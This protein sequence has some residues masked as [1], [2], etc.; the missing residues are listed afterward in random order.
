MKDYILSIIGVT[1]L[2]YGLQPEPELPPLVVTYK[3]KQEVKQEVQEVTPQVGDLIRTDRTVNLSHKEFNCLAYNIF[4]EAGVEDFAGKI[5]VAQVSNNRLKTD[6]YSNMCDVVYAHKQFS[7]TLNSS[8][9]YKQPHGPLWEES[10][11]AAKA[12]VNGV[13]VF[14][15]EQVKHYH[16][17][18]ANPK[19][20]PWTNRGEQ[21]AQLG[22]HI[23]YANVQ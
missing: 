8:K 15:L 7:W 14:G 5:A 20:V 13:R 11:K 6:R 12:F 21:V 17:E 19:A 9:R 16:A 22:A 10:L 1:A 18:Y 2:A 23:F 3:P 4:Y